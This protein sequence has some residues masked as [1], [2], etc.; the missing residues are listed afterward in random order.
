MNVLVES[1][2]CWPDVFVVVGL[3]SLQTKRG[4]RCAAYRIENNNDPDNDSDMNSLVACSNAIFPKCTDNNGDATNNDEHFQTTLL[5]V[6][7]VCDD[8][9]G[10]D[11]L[12]IL[13]KDTVSNKTRVRYLC[14]ELFLT[15]NEIS[16]NEK[17]FPFQLKYKQI[18]SLIFDI[19]HVI[20]KC[21]S[22][23]F[24]FILGYFSTKKK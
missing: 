2:K 13:F 10:L 22:K 11:R 7:T 21:S 17:Q 6:K 24:V 15:K 3:R 9:S 23:F 5:D 14:F 16:S 18:F 4:V 20:N 12:L 19:S 1:F 8:E